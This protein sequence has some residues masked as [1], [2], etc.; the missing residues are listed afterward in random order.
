VNLRRWRRDRNAYSTDGL[1]RRRRPCELIV[2]TLRGSSTSVVRCFHIFA[3]T[4]SVFHPGIFVGLHANTRHPA[5]QDDRTDP[6]PQHASWCMC[7]VAT[8]P[9]NRPDATV[10]DVLSGHVGNHTC[11][12]TSSTLSPTQWEQAIGKDNTARS[13]C[14][15]RMG[16]GSDSAKFPRPPDSQ[17]LACSRKPR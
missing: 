14:L 7:C 3:T 16:G 10:C 12:S 11:A 2:S 4:A 6:N 13:S 9:A 8:P 15:V 1:T 17:K 5:N